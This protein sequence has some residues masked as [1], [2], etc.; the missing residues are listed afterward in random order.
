MEHII[1]IGGGTGG[2]I[3]HDLTLRGFSVTLLEKGE[4]LS[5]AT[6]RHHGLLHSGARYVLHDVST[7]RECM[8]ENRILRHLA[9]DA[10]EQNGGLFV[11]MDDDDMA[12]RE[13]FV[14]G[15]HL[16]GIPIE[17]LSPAQ[18]LQ[19]EPNVSGRIKGGFKVPDAVMD[20][21]RLPLHFFASAKA[22]GADIR[23]YS[24][25]VEIVSSGGAV[26]GV[27]VLDHRTQRT[28]RLS[29]D[30]VVNAAG[31][32]AGKI[33]SLIDI[34]LPVQPGPGVMISVKAR[35]TNMVV[36]RLHPADDGDIVVPQRQLSLLG[37]T[38][39]LAENP[40]RIGVPQD[41][42][43]QILT[44]CAAMIPKVLT[45]P[46]HAAWSAARPLI[47]RDPMEAPTKISRSF[48]AIDHGATDGTEGFISVV[49]G[50]ATTMRAMAEKTADLICKKTGRDVACQTRVTKLL[51]YRRYFSPHRGGI[52][53][54]G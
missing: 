38:A 6:G 29:G 33:A 16:A 15:C 52:D 41:H 42:V 9:P 11:A 43:K 8:T 45:L 2:A 32:W 50:K 25:V 28:R 7:A 53:I 30:M 48:D 40:D 3:A 31:P 5:G 18:I 23:P 39:W 17:P 36:N 35:L 46:L 13:R 54:V 4:I 49:G 14:D 37:T 27:T 21:W 26:T 51:P 19:L 24:E 34:H 20:A 1:I 22:N 12:Y 47:V 10:L 44:G